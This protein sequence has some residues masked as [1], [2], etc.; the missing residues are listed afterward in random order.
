MKVQGLDV[1][2][3]MKKYFDLYFRFFWT[4][5]LLFCMY[6]IL[7]IWILPPI[8]LFSGSGSIWFIIKNMLHSI[9]N[10]N[11]KTNY[12]YINVICHSWNPSRCLYHTGWTLYLCSLEL[13]GQIRKD[14]LIYY[15]FFFFF[16]SVTYQERISGVLKWLDKAKSER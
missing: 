13:E 10:K 2:E 9:K 11:N 12:S 8:F 6:L 5:K 7:N 16:S 4:W 3:R 14:L 15:L 1:L